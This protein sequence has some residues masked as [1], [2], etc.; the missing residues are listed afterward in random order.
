[1]SSKIKLAN[2]VVD[3]FLEHTT[4]EGIKVSSLNELM[5][6]KDLYN[7]EKELIWAL[8]DL[9]KISYTQE[10]F[11]K[12]LT[13]YISRHLKD[14]TSSENL[15]AIYNKLKELSFNNKTIDDILAKADMSER[16]LVKKLAEHVDDI[17]KDHD[18]VET[19]LL[20]TMSEI[21]EKLTEVDKCLEQA[22]GILVAGFR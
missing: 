17:A 18:K 3:K 11:T 8:L 22:A 5:G 7:K 9:S 14:I 2:L 16:S 1:M 4:K 10:Q 6:L 20:V 21:Q 19:A 15:T 12:V 13:E